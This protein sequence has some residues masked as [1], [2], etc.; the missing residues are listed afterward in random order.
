MPIENPEVQIVGG[1]S[2]RAVIGTVTVSWPLAIAETDTT[3]VKVD[4]RPR[5]LKWIV[6]RFL[7]Q[8]SPKEDPLWEASWEKI[9]AVDVGRRT[10]TF[11]IEDGQGCRFGAAPN[12]LQPLLAALEA[13]SLC[14]RRVRTTLG[15]YVNR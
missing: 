11:Q 2:F 1:A 3:G 14:L 4:V 12:K 8:P 15:W 13:R 9:S 7:D 10:V 6:R 5:L